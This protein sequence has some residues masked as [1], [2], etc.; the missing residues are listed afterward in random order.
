MPQFPNPE[1]QFRKGQSGNPGGK[2]SAQRKREI[3]NAK[4]AT[5]I[6]S[7]LLKA[8]LEA[9]EGGASLDMIEAAILKLIK[10]AEDRGLGAPQQQV[11]HSGGVSVE[12]IVRK[13]V[14][15]L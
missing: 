6:R 11:E 14:D 12:T 8:A 2:T 13:V 4:K 9:S 5:L 10:D 15:P 3:A 7:R 1:T